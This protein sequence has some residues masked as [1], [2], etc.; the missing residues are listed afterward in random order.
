MDCETIESRL[1][2]AYAREAYWDFLPLLEI[3]RQSRPAGK[4]LNDLLARRLRRIES[5]VEK[6]L[7]L[8]QPERLE[9]DIR[10]QGFVELSLQ[11][12]IQA[13]LQAGAHV[14]A[15]LRLREP[16]TEGEIFETLGRAGWLSPDLAERLAKMALLHNSL[17]HDYEDIDLAIVR[18]IVEHRLGDL[19]EF[20]AA[21]RCRI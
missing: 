17:I 2:A 5:C 10:Q 15:D 11:V 18:D 20:V 9:E 1:R 14:I 8:A 19:L 21:I 13:A 12:A 6:L 3:C 4:S 16:T 7:E